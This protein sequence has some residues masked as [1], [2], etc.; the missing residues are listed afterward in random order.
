MPLLDWD[1]NFSTRIAVVDEQHKKIVDLIN[2][3]YDELSNGSEAGRLDKLIKELIQ[4]SQVH[5][6]TEEDL[7][8]KYKYPQS[9]EHIVE[10]QR[11]NVIMMNF[12]RDYL[13]GKIGAPIHIIDFITLWLKGHILEKDRAYVPFLADEIR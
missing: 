12:H 11:F 5:F 4:C 9:L 6:K 3:I 13:D 1:D 7:F 10:H 2:E 8:E